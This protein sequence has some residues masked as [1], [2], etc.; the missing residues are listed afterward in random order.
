METKMKQFLYLLMA[1]FVACPLFTSCS[2]DDENLPADVPEGGT[3]ENY[4]QQACLQDALVEMDES[5][6]FVRCKQGY[7][8]DA[9]NP[10]SFSIQADNVEKA[11]IAFKK[12]FTPV[13]EFV[14]AE[15]GI[16]A[17]LVDE[18]GKSQGYVSFTQTTGEADG[19][20]AC[21]TFHTT[22]E[23]KFVSELRYLPV[24]DENNAF[25]FSPFEVGD[26][27]KKDVGLHGLGRQNWV[28]LREATSS[29]KGLLVYISPKS[30]KGYWDGSSDYAPLKDVETV[31]DIM[32]SNWKKYT[33]YLKAAGL[34]ADD[35]ITVWYGKIKDKFFYLRRDYMNLQ[36][37]KT[38]WNNVQHKYNK[39]AFILVEYFD[40]ATF[41]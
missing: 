22:P 17:N 39:R 27:V 32:R 6:N 25:Q 8:L 12:L 7:S 4:D 24:W 35:N 38:D 2:D 13:V 41:E 18:D 33:G 1:C 34:G 28:C 23:I 5:G 29:S 14:E 31:S 10:T 20:I 30:Y 21:V 3:I 15:G 19:A 9:A 11:K 36:T 26:M 37:G 40:M 16:T